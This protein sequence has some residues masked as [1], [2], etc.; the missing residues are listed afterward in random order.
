MASDRSKA[1][2]YADGQRFM[3]KNTAEIFSEIAEQNLWMESESVS[4]FGSSLKQTEELVAQLPGI[5]KKFG[6]KKLLDAPC[7]DFNW[8]KTVDLSGIE[9]TGGD[10]VQS[11]VDANNKAYRGSNNQFYRL[12]LLADPLGSHDLL[13]CRD[14]L[15]HL[16][17]EDIFKMLGKL[18]SSSVRYLMTTTF[19]EEN[20]NQDVP[21]GGWR[22]LNFQSAPFHFPEPLFVLNEKCT[23]MDGMFGDKS[24]GVWEVNSLP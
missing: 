14:C 20:S 13:F 17:F 7:G 8:M 9:Y 23:E 2:L 11:I 22:P 4:G 10:I 24:M 5:F 1:Y 6:V 21:T 12:D 3:G 18:K 15:V 19:P 16:S